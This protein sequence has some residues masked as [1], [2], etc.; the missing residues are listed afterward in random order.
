MLAFTI[1]QTYNHGIAYLVWNALR[2]EGWNSPGG[3]LIREGYRRGRRAK[4]LAEQDW[5]ELFERPIDEVRKELGVGAPPDYE[6]L[7]TA[8]APA[9][10]A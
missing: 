4:P 9:L 8:G 7:R 6:Q 3:K 10:S 2:A 5:E 1:A